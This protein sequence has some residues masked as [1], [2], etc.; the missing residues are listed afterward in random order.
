[1]STR[2]IHGFATSGPQSNDY[3]SFDTKNQTPRS[4]AKSKQQELSPAEYRMVIKEAIPFIVKAS[5]EASREAVEKNVLPTLVKSL[6]T[7]NEE[8][9]KALNHANHHLGVT[10]EALEPVL[11]AGSEQLVRVLHKQ[12]RSQRE[13]II[14][15][16]AELKKKENDS[17]FFG[18]I[19]NKIETSVDDIL[20]SIRPV[21]SSNIQPQAEGYVRWD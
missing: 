20:K 3:F 4:R 11:F 21:P 17:N 18:D 16:S 15:R 7:H 5:L 8:T 6:S 12:V 9:D 14:F 2:N 19:A 13:E 1:M 10:L